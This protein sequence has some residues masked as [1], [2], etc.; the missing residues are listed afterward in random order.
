MIALPNKYVTRLNVLF[1]FCIY[2]IFEFNDRI[3]KLMVG[4]DNTKLTA[5]HK[6]DVV[7][8]NK[9]SPNNPNKRVAIFGWIKSDGKPI[10]GLNYWSHSDI[11][12]DYTLATSCSNTIP[13]C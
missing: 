10:Q 5:G 3:N 13:I 12:V 8:T 4:L 6:K 1:V 7:L 9:L 11:Y 2:F